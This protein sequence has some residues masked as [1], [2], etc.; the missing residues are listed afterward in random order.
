MLEYPINSLDKQHIGYAEVK[1]TFA[2]GSSIV[3]H[4]ND[5]DSHQ[6]STM[7]RRERL[8]RREVLM[9]LKIQSGTS[10]LAT[11]LESLTQTTTNEAS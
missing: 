11:Y 2:D 8:L 3:Y 4:Y 6:M 7:S 10:I 5:Y 9:M 1:E